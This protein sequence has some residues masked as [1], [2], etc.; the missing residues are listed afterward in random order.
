MYTARMLVFKLLLASLR[1]LHHRIDT[2]HEWRWHF[3]WRSWL[4][5]GDGSTI[6][7]NSKNW[8]LYTISE[9]DWPAGAYP[10]CK[11]YEIL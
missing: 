10:L 4:L 9:Y 8:K 5:C 6:L 3:A 11:F 7:Q 1:F 2:L